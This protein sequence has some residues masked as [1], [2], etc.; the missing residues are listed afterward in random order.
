MSDKKNIDRLFQEKF[1]DFEASPHKRVW[2]NI[3]Q[4]LRKDKK[5]RFIP[6]LW[7]KVAGVAAAITLLIFLANSVWQNKESEVVNASPENNEVLENDANNTIIN[8]SEEK[9]KE[10]F[11]STET[12]S[13]REN[14]NTKARKEPENQRLV[15]NASNSKDSN[16]TNQNVDSETGKKKKIELSN[17]S[18]DKEKS[19]VTA[20]Q[21]NIA[22]AE[23]QTK[24][25]KVGT[26]IASYSKNEIALSEDS[27]SKK[28]L[29][30]IADKSLMNNAKNL[31]REILDEEIAVTGEGKKSQDVKEIVVTKVNQDSIFSKEILEEENALAQRE[32]ELK[33]EN[34]E[35]KENIESETFNRWN[36]RPNVSPV[37]YGNLGN[38][39]SPIDS[40]FS[41]N[42]ASGEVSMAYGVNFAYSVSKKLKVRTGVSKVQLNYSTNDVAF[43]SSVKP[44][45]LSGVDANARTRNIQVVSR[46][47]QNI[48]SSSLRPDINPYTSGALKQQIGFI[49]VPIEIEYALLDTRFGIHIVGGASSLI[50]NE[51]E[52]AVSSAEGVTNLGEAN[53]LNKLSF[54][55]NLGVGFG[56]EISKKL[57]FNVEP[58]FKYQINTFTGN[59]NGFKPYYF[60]VYT[61]VNFKF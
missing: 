27:K 12:V 32:R 8:S 56:Y 53:N 11:V 33:E 30:E 54:S 21:E 57:D 37:Y 40:Q 7:Y 5:R 61:G 2:K 26:E 36:I 9:A 23:A 25:K 34:L 38:S 4:E 22:S 49:E 6:I 42:D 17:S 13:P 48:P 20:N 1:K 24:E 18:S 50:L 52:V 10:N 14:E 55:T 35:D 43:T 3:E 51:N 58:T 16:F 41:N 47:A 31:K 46:P 19:G 45:G 44:I 60:G 28:D 29:N 15:E 59:T 39:G